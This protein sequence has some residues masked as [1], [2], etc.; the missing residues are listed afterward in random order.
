MFPEFEFPRGDSDI[1]TVIKKQLTLNGLN[2]MFAS[3]NCKISFSS[4]WR[5]TRFKWPPDNKKH[6]R[7]FGINFQG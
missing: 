7:H 1:K 2:Q 3:E 6:H 5:Y 4:E